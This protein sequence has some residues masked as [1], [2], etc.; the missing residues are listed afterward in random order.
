M[1][2]RKNL[3]TT[4]QPAFFNPF[5]KEQE[6]V[7]LPKQ[8]LEPV[9]ATATKKEQRRLERIQVKLLGDD[10]AEPIDG[11]THV[12]IPAGDEYMV[13]RNMQVH[14]TFIFCKSCN[15]F[16]SRL[17]D[18]CSVISKEKAPYRTVMESGTGVADESGTQVGVGFS[19]V[20]N[21]CSPAK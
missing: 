14:H 3:D 6:T 11:L 19:V 17:S 16:C 20:A 18:V 9:P 12:R 8:G 4:L 5:V 15:V 7:S 1:N 13:C 21:G 10:G 2:L